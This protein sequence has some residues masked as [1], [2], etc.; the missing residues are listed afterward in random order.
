LNSLL[1]KKCSWIVTQNPQKT[2]LRDYS[3]YIENGV[4]TDITRNPRYEAG[5]AIDGKGMALL[6][7]LINTHTHL[8]M[9]LLRGY[10]DDMKLGEWLEK[11]V[12]PI[13]RKFTKKHCYFGALLGCLEMISTGTTCVM[14][15]YMHS[16]EAAKAVRQAG[17]RAFIGCG[18]IDFFDPLLQPSQISDAKK[19]AAFIQEM[20]DPRIH[21]AISPHSLFTCSEELLLKAKDLADRE[22]LPLQIHAAETRREQA[23][24]ER[25]HGMREIEFLDKIGFLD[26][27]VI[28]VHC[29]WITKTEVKTLAKHGVKVSHCPVSN[30]K[31][32]EGGVAPIPEMFENGVAVSLGTDSAASNNSLDMF[33]TMKFCALVHK[34][35]RWD[36]TVLPAQKVLDLATIDGAHALGLSNM[37]GSVEVG[38][39]ADLILVNLNS[40]N[41]APIHGE[42]TL[43]SH[44]VYSAKGS[45]V[46]TTIVNGEI[47]MRGRKILT[48][49]PRETLE[50]AQKLASELIL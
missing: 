24:F 16:E 34:A 50:M 22:H 18:V 29:V 19:R 33:E 45:N 21:A 3:V 17:L 31:L 44:L 10:A 15:M 28:A 30:M 25:R 32:A 46:D 43:I 37:V 13:E 49:N 27:N 12:W 36:P 2:I 42:E 7:G 4:I 11:R 48:L 40:P 8:P 6:P 14:D 20:N 47:L 26:E 9:T 35:H 23:D 38:K 5:Q 1:I 41:L 39:L